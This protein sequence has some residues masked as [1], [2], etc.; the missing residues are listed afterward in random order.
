MNKTLVRSKVVLEDDGK[1]LVTYLWKKTFWLFGYWYP[2]GTVYN[3]SKIPDKRVNRITDELVSDVLFENVLK[4][5]CEH[6]DWVM[7]T[8]IRKIRCK[9]CGIEG[10]VKDYENLFK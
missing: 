4:E 2:F 6:K 3:G 9:K 10:F 1:A 7:D 5:S 8:Q